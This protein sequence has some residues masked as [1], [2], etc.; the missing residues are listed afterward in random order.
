MLSTID[1]M[2]SAVMMIREGG[3]VWRSEEAEG[4]AESLEQVYF[5]LAGSSEM[6]EL[7]WLRSSPS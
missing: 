3:V 7:T 2:P 1:E 5:R 6:D 4:R